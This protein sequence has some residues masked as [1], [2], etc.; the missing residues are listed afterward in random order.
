MRPTTA[1]T[2]QALL[3]NEGPRLTSREAD[4]DRTTTSTNG[5]S[6]PYGCSKKPKAFGFQVMTTRFSVGMPA[7][8]SLPVTENSLGAPRRS[9][10]PFFRNDSAGP[11]QAGTKP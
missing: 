6:R 4:K 5:L 7:L 11:G 3:G 8:A 2:M 9:P 10:S 1:L